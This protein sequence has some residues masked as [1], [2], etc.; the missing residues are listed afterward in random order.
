MNAAY[1]PRP[2]PSQ[3]PQRE[4]QSTPIPL[5]VWGATDTG[6]Q[7]EGNEDAIFPHSGTDTFTFKPSPQHLAQ[8]GQLLVVADGV[9]GAQGGREASNW[10]IRVAVERYYD[11][12]GPDL[13]ANLRT[14]VEVANS[15]LYQYI[16][17]TGAGE[18]GCTMAAAVIHGNTLHVANVGDSRIYLLRGGQITQLTR[19]HTLAQQKADQGIIRPEQVETDSGSHVLT[20]SMGASQ[21]VQVDLFPPLQL[22]PGDVVLACSDGLTDML[23]N[24]EIARVIGNHPPRRAAQRLIAAAN[25]NGGVDNISVVI[26]RAG[27]EQLADQG[28][29]VGRFLERTKQQRII[30]AALVAITALVLFVAVIALAWTVHNRKPATPSPITPATAI[31]STEMTVPVV[32]SDTP[33]PTAAGATPQIQSTSTPKPTNTPTPSP[34]PDSEGPL[35]ATPRTFQIEPILPVS[36]ET[37]KNPIA[38]EWRGSLQTD[39]AYQIRLYHVESGHTISSEPLTD[40]SW[41]ADLPA[42]QYGGWRWQVLVIRDGEIVGASQEWMFWFNPGG[43]GS[44]DGPKPT[45]PPAR[46]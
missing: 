16:Q 12:T 21:T 45:S 25:R 38:F 40:P 4:T 42:D 31:L 44:D 33:H 41:V 19:D 15:S 29:I 7:R 39:Q 23:K 30:I 43:G 8:K 17:S 20:R 36:G 5:V 1:P 22:V 14:S 13:G 26:V 32:A 37:Y 35:T 11:M 2:S 18:S 46:P 24:A 10:A 6:R 34:T 3:H 27:E 9:G 28:G